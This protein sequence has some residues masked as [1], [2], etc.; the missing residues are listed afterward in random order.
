M[1]W[2]VSAVEFSACNNPNVG[3]NRPRFELTMYSIGM[4]SMQGDM[5]V[6]GEAVRR[7]INQWI[8]ISG[9]IGVSA[10]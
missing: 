3:V 6:R 1:Q 8:G 9:G 5:T 7:R 2:R 10:R 4:H